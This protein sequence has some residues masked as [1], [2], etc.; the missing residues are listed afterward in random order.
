MSCNY[1]TFDGAI[2]ERFFPWL[3]SFVGEVNVGVWRI[4][5]TDNFGNRVCEGYIAE[6]SWTISA[7]AF[8]IL[9]V[10]Y[11]TGAMLEYLGVE[12]CACMRKCCCRCA[13]PSLAF[14]AMICQG[15]TFL[16]VK[17]AQYGDFQAGF[18]YNVVAAAC[19]LLA[20]LI[21]GRARLD[22]PADEEEDKLHEADEQPQV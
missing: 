6:S 17:W 5:V 13:G 2:F 16:F 12:S 14:M 19:Y 20:A 15:L 21:S 4:G 8:S 18:W 10:I 1:A 11:G 22:A 3:G 7:R 9:A